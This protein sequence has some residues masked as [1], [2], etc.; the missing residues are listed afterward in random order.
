V[1]VR[2]R[3]GSE[4]ADLLLDR[5]VQGSLATDK[6]SADVRVHLRVTENHGQIIPGGLVDVH[7][8]INDDTGDARQLDGLAAD[9][10]LEAL[11]TDQDDI[12]VG[13]IL[14]LIAGIGDVDSGSGQ[15]DASVV[16]DG[17]SILVESR[18]NVL[19]TNKHKLVRASE[20]ALVNVLLVDR[21]GILSALLNGQR[22]TNLH[23]DSSHAAGSGDLMSWD[24]A[25]D[26]ALLQSHD[27]VQLLDP[28]IG[29]LE[30]FESRSDAVVDGKIPLQGARGSLSTIVAAREAL[31]QSGNS[32]PAVIRG[33]LIDLLTSP[34]AELCQTS[35][36]CLLLVACTCYVVSLCRLNVLWLCDWKSRLSESAKGCSKHDKRLKRSKQPLDAS[37]V[38]LPRINSPDDI[39]TH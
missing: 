25:E 22:S 21:N 34:R 32:Q 2:K 37:L 5:L 35:I 39:Q 11:D 31:V 13:Q 28:Q 7:G 38:A 23:D 4:V 18:I 9:E 16:G 1:P 19:V 33:D 30:V 3:N 10:L 17:Q 36:P 29:D 27:Q 15:V 8:L 12:G 14:V 6:D 26:L 20:D 24:D